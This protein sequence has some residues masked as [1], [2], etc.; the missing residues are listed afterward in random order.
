MK[1]KVSDQ[2]LVIPPEWLAG[3]DEV[4]IRREESAIVI[5]PVGDG[6]PIR[7]LGKEPIETDVQDASEHHDRYVYDP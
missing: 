3:V 2:G 5:L 4:E 6:D 7:Q 1:A